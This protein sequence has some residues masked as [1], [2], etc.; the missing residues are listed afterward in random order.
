MYYNFHADMTTPPNMACVVIPQ[1]VRLVKTPCVAA[2]ETSEMFAQGH[3]VSL[4]RVKLTANQ[5]IRG[6]KIYRVR[7][8][9][10]CTKS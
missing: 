7:T 3:P 6:R 2:L 10:P 8:H 4:D 5:K 1:D 9:C